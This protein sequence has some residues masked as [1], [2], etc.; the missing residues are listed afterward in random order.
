MG[1]E[2]GPEQAAGLLLLPLVEL[3]AALPAGDQWAGEKEFVCV[4]VFVGHAHIGEVWVS[5]RREMRVRVERRPMVTRLYKTK[6][7]ITTHRH[8]T[9]AI[10]GG[11]GLE[12][13]GAGYRS[14]EADMHCWGLSLWAG[15]GVHQVA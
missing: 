2:G 11:H 15:P 12:G 4:S 14:K 10:P 7:N 1:Q 5:R 6:K 13:V 9:Q 3:E 8:I